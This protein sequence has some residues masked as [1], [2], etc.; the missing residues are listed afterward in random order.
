[1]AFLLRW[2]TIGVVTDSNVSL[3]DQTSGI[4]GLGF[5]RL[6]S[7][8]DSGPNCSSKFSTQLSLLIGT[9]KFRL[10]LLR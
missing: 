6:S 7:I 8:S 3:T 5:P 4:M 10:F 1:M 2:Y 9:L